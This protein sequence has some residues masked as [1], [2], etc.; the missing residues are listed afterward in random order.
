MLASVVNLL[1]R[2]FGR[3]AF[4]TPG[5]YREIWH[6]AYPLIMMSAT[7]TLMMFVDRKMLASHS[8]D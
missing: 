2:Y 5:G 1:K 6:I 3:E 7:Q 4:M 8:T